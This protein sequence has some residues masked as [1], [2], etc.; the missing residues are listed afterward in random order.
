[1]SITLDLPAELE[2]ELVA[3][4]TQL[5]LPLTEYILQVLLGRSLLQNP[6]RTGAELV[7]YWERVGAIGSRP[8]IVDSQAHARQLRREAE[9]RERS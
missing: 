8:D 9:Q 4:A 5:K 2:A 3:E 6:P 1:M 7:A